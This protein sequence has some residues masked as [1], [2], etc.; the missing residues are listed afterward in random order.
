MLL[1]VPHTRPEVQNTVG[2]GCRKASRH[3]DQISFRGIL[4]PCTV[5][6]LATYA[7]DPL[8]F[9]R[10]L[11]EDPVV[12]LFKNLETHWHHLF[13]HAWRVMM[14]CLSAKIRLSLILWQQPERCLTEQFK[15][16]LDPGAFPH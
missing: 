11:G 5:H 16:V 13:H 15:G 4:A 1:A 10:F 12:A 9:S 8:V 6:C 7:T 2:E 3:V 14:Q